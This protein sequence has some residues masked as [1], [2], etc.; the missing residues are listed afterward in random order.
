[1][2][3]GSNIKSWEANINKYYFRL[4]KMYSSLINLSHIAKINKMKIKIL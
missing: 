4:L 2:F 1:M 3:Y